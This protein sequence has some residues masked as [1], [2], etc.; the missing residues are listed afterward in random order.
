MTLACK[1]D[2]VE[3]VGRVSNLPASQGVRKGR[4]VVP[5][6]EQQ[7]MAGLPG[8][9]KSRKD[10]SWIWCSVLVGEAARAIG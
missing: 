5:A 10:G 1:R 7:W 8:K 4:G 3:Q 6:A 2:D 9:C